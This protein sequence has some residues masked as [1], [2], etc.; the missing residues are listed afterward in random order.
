MAMAAIEA[1]PFGGAAGGWKGP[2][3]VS[4]RKFS[5]GG[6]LGFVRMRRAVDEEMVLSALGSACFA[7]PSRDG[8]RGKFVVSL[9]TNDGASARNSS[10]GEREMRS[11]SEFEEKGGD[12]VLQR[13]YCEMDNAAYIPNS[14][15]GKRVWPLL[16]VLSSIDLVFDEADW[17]SNFHLTKL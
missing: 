13:Q 1:M 4:G 9:A 8:V 7:V 10:S 15:D 17:T 2:V 5:R 3:L 6:G 16:Q 11:D 12:N 14:Q